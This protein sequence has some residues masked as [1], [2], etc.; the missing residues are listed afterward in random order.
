[1]VKEYTFINL[2]RAAAAF[3]VLLEHCL[4]WGGWH[5][6]PL[7]PAKIGVDLFMIISGFLMAANATARSAFEPLTTRRNWIRFWGR[8]FFRIAPAYYLSLAVAAVA[9]AHFLGGYAELQKLNPSPWPAGGVYDPARFEYSPGNILLHL[10]F[11]FGLHPTASFSTFLPD[12]SLSLEMQFYAAFPLLFVVMRKFGIVKTALGLGLPVFILGYGIS[13]LVPY[14]EPSLLCFKLNYFLAGMVLY[15]V[16]AD[17]TGSRRRF[18]LAAAALLLVSIDLR[19]GV[20][21]MVPPVLLM[22]MLTLGWLERTRR[23]PAW[24]EGVLDSRPVHFAS[25]ASYGVYLF[26]GFFISASG[27]LIS[28]NATLLSLTPPRRVLFMLV[29]V[30]TLAYPLAYLVYRFV[31]LP[32]IR[33]GKRMMGFIRNS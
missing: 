6:I 19:Y 21:L 4:V 9:G 28:G 20:N 29:F 7:P 25:D 15:H 11:L 23:T 17:N 5:G 22:S 13:A 3:W 8:R 33:F 30:T 27:W 10:S 32:G 16:L 2:F 31:E 18:V 24:L 26:H 14:Y 1:M 12:W